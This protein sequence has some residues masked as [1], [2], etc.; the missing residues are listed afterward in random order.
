[1]VLSILIYPILIDRMSSFYVYHA[2]TPMVRIDRFKIVRDVNVIKG[3]LNFARSRSKNV[4]RK[5]GEAK[6]GNH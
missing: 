2:L 4:E 6:S 5:D 3:E 1:M